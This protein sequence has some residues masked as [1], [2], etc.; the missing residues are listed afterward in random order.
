MKNKPVCCAIAVFLAA[1]AMYGGED[2]RLNLRADD[3]QIP[4]LSILDNVEPAELPDVNSANSHYSE[5]LF[6]ASVAEMQSA[7]GDVSQDTSA[8]EGV[9][10]TILP[11]PF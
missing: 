2:Y 3:L 8:R 6:A 1:Q 4:E 5:Q 11:Y 10:F 9:Q 7:A